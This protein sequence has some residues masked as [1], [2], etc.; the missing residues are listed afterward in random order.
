MKFDVAPPLQPFVANAVSSFA[1][2]TRIVVVGFSFGDADLY[3]SRMLVKALQASN[4]TKLAIIDPD[5][6]VG[7]KVRRKFEALIPGFDSASRVLR[8]RG[9]GSQILPQFLSEDLFG[10]PHDHPTEIPR[11]REEDSALVKS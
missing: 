9:D 10:S 6:G 8:L 4:E 1:D 11:E 5:P 2:K 7:H 3:I